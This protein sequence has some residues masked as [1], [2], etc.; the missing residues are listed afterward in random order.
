M[1]RTKKP[2][3]QATLLENLLKRKKYLKGKENCL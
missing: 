3:K 2:G 1:I